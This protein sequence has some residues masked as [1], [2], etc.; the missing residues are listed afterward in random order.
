[1]TQNIYDD[2]GFFEAYG[3]LPRSRQGLEGAPEWPALQRLLPPIDAR[4]VLDLGCGL[5]WFSRWAADSGARSVLGIDLSERMLADA[6]QDAIGQG[7]FRTPRPGVTDP[8]RAFLR[9][10]LQLPGPALR[11]AIA[12]AA[13]FVL[14]EIEEW[15]PSSEQIADHPEWACERHRPP[16]LLVSAKRPSGRRG[17]TPIPRARKRES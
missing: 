5:G 9:P 15:G 8:A 14:Q 17:S 1:M 4:E 16:F 13:G 7:P 3:R 6:R 10:D 2:P 11:G 12:G